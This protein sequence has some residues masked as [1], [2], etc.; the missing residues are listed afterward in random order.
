[1]AG[2]NEDISPFLQSDNAEKEGELTEIELKVV[3]PQPTSVFEEDDEDPYN[4]STDLTRYRVKYNKKKIILASIAA[5]VVVVLTLI[6]IHFS[7]SY[8]FYS[9]L[10][11]G[12]VDGAKIGKEEFEN[13]GTKAV[14]GL[15]ESDISLYY[16]LLRMNV[17]IESDGEILSATFLKHPTRYDLAV[18]ISHSIAANR[19]DILNKAMLYIKLGFN[20]M[21]YDIRSHGLSTG[22]GCSFGYFEKQ[23]LLEVVEY[24]RR[25]LP[26]AVIGVH[27]ESLGAAISLQFLEISKITGVDEEK[28][29]TTDF[30]ISDSSFASLVDEIYFTEG[31]SQGVIG[32]QIQTADYLAKYLSGFKFSKVS[33]MD[34][35]TSKNAKKMPIYFIHGEDDSIVPDTDSLDMFNKCEGNCKLWQV[36]DCGHIEAYDLY[37]D[38]YAQNLIEFLGSINLN[39][40]LTEL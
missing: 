19:W 29:L 2:D 15:N 21:I 34:G 25:I 28:V 14:E 22:D 7:V 36:K 6:A 26:M 35:V 17:T 16:S 8:Y 11:Y 27:G 18:V 24:V 40:S 4:I 20:V 31:V 33:P 9:S 32:L 13:I 30:V 3:S 5:G 37:P 23:D 1:M 12:T 39:I 38:L 10:V